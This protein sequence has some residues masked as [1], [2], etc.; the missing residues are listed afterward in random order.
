MGGFAV[1][2]FEK[3]GFRLLDEKPPLAD[4]GFILYVNTCNCYEK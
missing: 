1:F 3:G 4:S 2:M